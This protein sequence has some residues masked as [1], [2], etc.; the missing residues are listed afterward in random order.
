MTYSRVEYAVDISARTNAGEALA[1]AAWAD[2]VA[3]FE[4][5][6][7]LVGW[8]WWA[9]GDP[10]GWWPDVAAN[11][12]GH[13]SISPTSPATYTGDTVNMDMIEGDF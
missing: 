11:G 2:F 9:G 1:P 7:V 6:P 12:G 8:T 3:Y 4:S 10:R 5:Q 13:Y